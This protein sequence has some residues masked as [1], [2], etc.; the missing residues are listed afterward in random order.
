MWWW[1]TAPLKKMAKKGI[2]F[3][4][5][6]TGLDSIGNGYRLCILEDVNGWIGD[7]QRVDIT[8]AFKA[9]GENDNGRRMVEFWARWSRGEEHD[10]SSAGEG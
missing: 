4:M 8:G 9:L 6:W 3:G 1:G 5:T 10:R 7:R 2:G